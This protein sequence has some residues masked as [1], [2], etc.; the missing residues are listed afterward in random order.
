MGTV[1]ANTVRK[2]TKQKPRSRRKYC[3]WS[4]TMWRD[5]GFDDREHLELGLCRAMVAH[6]VQI[7]PERVAIASVERSQ[8][9]ARSVEGWLANKAPWQDRRIVA[10]S[11]DFGRSAKFTL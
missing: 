8:L 2:T 11:A 4:R 6:R 7:D 1:T 9:S 5:P 3:A 10:R